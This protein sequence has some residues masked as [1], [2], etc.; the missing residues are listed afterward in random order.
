MNWGP[1]RREYCRAPFFARHYFSY[2]DACRRYSS[3][4]AEEPHVGLSETWSRIAAGLG[5]RLDAFVPPDRP[6]GSDEAFRARMAVGISFMMSLLRAGVTTAHLAAGHTGHAAING[7]L[8]SVTFAAP[9]AIRRRGTYPLVLNATLATS[10]VAMAV[11]AMTNRSQGF[12]GATLA[13][14]ET[15][16]FAALLGGVRVG[17]VWTA[18]SCA[19]SASVGFLGDAR[20]PRPRATAALN[21]H[22]VL[23][24]VTVTTF[25]VAALYEHRRVWQLAQIAHLE[26]QRRAT[27]LAREHTL[28][29]AQLAQS[30]HLT[31]LGRIAEAVAHEM[32]NPLSYVLS[33]LEFLADRLEKQGQEADL[34]DAIADGMD[35]ARRLE[36]IV[37]DLFQFLRPL[38]A[39][40]RDAGD[41]VEAVR[42]ALESAA[43]GLRDKATVK[44]ALGDI[45]LV[46]GNTLRLKHVFVNL[47]LHAAREIPGGRLAEHRIEIRG[48]VEPGHVRVEVEH[49]GEGLSRDVAEP[50]SG[51][52]VSTDPPGHGPDLGLALTHTILE[53]VGGSLEFESSAGRSIACI[54]LATAAADP[55]SGA[56][57]IS[58]ADA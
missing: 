42:A 45:P 22:L 6:A 29:D 46:R 48:Y 57:R 16:L 49:T 20:L 12:S 19:V 28:S 37:A 43:G 11:S 18:I 51:S 53:A 4:G 10:V 41:V 9:F 30:E 13:L 32:N 24:T 31:S 35:G 55:P 36:R 50:R 8:A 15:P 44:V 40:T 34:R 47:V 38:R 27:E 39:T 1:R 25:L 2:R 5:T 21:E 14:A 3:G 7:V 33:N 23:L 52:M 56:T 17:A 58:G 54:R 26:T